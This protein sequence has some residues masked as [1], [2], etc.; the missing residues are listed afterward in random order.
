MRTSRLF[1]TACLALL[2]SGCS[3]GM[4]RTEASEAVLRQ[5]HDTPARFTTVDG[6]MPEDACRTT[7]ID[8]RDQTSL[9]LARSAQHG[10][11]YRGDYEVPD[12][13]YGV[14]RG[15]LL[16]VDCASGEVIGI[17]RN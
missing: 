5:A 16:R 8:P 15:E 17:V 3:I 1:E 7:I 2:M 9:R 14:G 12:G 11:I 10:M 6:V 13:R 4:E